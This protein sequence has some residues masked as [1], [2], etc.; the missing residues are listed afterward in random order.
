MTHPI[1]ILKC[2]ISEV[3]GVRFILPRWYTL[4]DVGQLQRKQKHSWP[5]KKNTTAERTLR[6]SSMQC[7]WVAQSIIVCIQTD[8]VHK[9][10]APRLNCLMFVHRCVLD[11]NKY[12][13]DAASMIVIASDLLF[14]FDA[15]H[16]LCKLFLCTTN[17]WRFCATMVL[18]S[19][20]F[21]RDLLHAMPQAYWYLQ[22]GDSRVS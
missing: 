13:F 9:P 12:V 11:W 14:W 4:Y 20:P 22:H 16:C 7:P 5:C 10:D 1:V 2:K 18:T 21:F 15:C 8:C 19:G 6:S 3:M 17:Q